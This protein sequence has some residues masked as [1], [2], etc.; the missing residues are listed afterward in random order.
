MNKLDLQGRVSVIT[1]GSGAIGLAIARR[2]VDSGAKVVI[3]DVNGEAANAAARKLGAPLASKVDVTD[4]A[5]VAAAAREAHAGL[6]S[7]DVL[8]NAAGINGPVEPVD[9]YP[10]DGW[11]QVLEINLTGVFICCRET[12]PY[13][14]KARH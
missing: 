11:R 10:I 3:W 9:S 7:I 13:L 5:S 4:H 2:F 6:G 14:R 1:G 8:I 12:L